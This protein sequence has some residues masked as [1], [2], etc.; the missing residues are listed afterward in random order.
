MADD[1]PGNGKMRRTVSVISHT[2][3][4]LGEALGMMGLPP[5]WPFSSQVEYDALRGLRRRIVMA[6]PV[7]LPEPSDVSRTA[8]ATWI[9]QTRKPQSVRAGI[10]PQSGD[11]PA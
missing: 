11:G 3:G 6:S 10:N 7:A 1:N 2:Q 8:I 4:D 5:F 9:V